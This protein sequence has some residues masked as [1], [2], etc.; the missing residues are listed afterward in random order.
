MNDE[1]YINSVTLEYLLN[2]VLYEKIS[3]QKNQEDNLIFKDI[4]FY[5]KRICQLTKE[6]CKGE[7]INDNCKTIF[8]NY[9][10]TLVYHLKQLD[11]KDI[12]QED[13]KNLTIKSITT[14][15]TDSSNNLD[16]IDNLL[17]NMPIKTANLDSFVKK[18]NVNMED[19]ILPQRKVANI[20]DP[21][22]KKKGLKKKISS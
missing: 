21:A 9:A 6:M 2:P 13:Y 12:Y 10:N 20:K 5:R 19:K 4:L 11:T 8:L 3:C 16:K 14:L 15:S 18:V 7:Y 17:I 1:E 22:L